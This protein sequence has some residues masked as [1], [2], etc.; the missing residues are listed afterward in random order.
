M[1]FN[2]INKKA[3]NERMKQFKEYSATKASR[4]A[5]II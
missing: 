2:K 5:K 3:N 1:D 4:N